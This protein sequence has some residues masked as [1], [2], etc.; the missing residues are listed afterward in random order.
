[1]KR[2]VEGGGLD[3]ARRNRP[4]EQQYVI[5][6][7][8]DPDGGT[9]RA[10]GRN[11]AGGKASP[12]RDRAADNLA[13][14]LRRMMESRNEP[15][16]CP[17]SPRSASDDAATFGPGGYQRGRT[18]ATG[19]NRGNDPSSPPPAPL[20]GDPWRRFGHTRAPGAGFQVRVGKLR[21]PQIF[22]E[23]WKDLQLTDEAMKA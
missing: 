14:M 12:H 13:A 21:I 18:T 23:I 17:E 3:L 2:N 19:G 5:L 8:S 10:A 4:V 6:L 7:Q 1:V 20:K 15:G 16:R 11:A 9:R 22:F